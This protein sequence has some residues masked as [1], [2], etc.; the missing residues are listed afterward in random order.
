MIDNTFNSSIRLRDYKVYLFLVLVALL[1]NTIGFIMETRRIDKL[2]L[3]HPVYLIS[4][5]DADNKIMSNTL[6]EGVDYRRPY[7]DLTYIDYLKDI[8]FKK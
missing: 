8:H 5:E 7:K 3:I 2:H 4:K 6:V 1:L